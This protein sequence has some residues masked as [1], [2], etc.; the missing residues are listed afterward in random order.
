MENRMANVFPNRKCTEIAQ[1]KILMVYIICFMY[2]G[3]FALVINPLR[4]TCTL[5][6]HF[7]LKYDFLHDALTPPT[8]DKPTCF[9]GIFRY[10]FNF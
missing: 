7:V 3:I 4:D 2:A 5:S 6:T 8:H 10:F 9:F 1:Y